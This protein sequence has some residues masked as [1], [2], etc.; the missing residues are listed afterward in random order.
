[1]HR[2]MKP[3]ISL[4]TAVL[5]PALIS[6]ILPAPGATTVFWDDL[7]DDADGQDV[8]TAQIGTWGDFAGDRNGIVRHINT[9]GISAPPGGG[10]K[11]LQ[12]RREGV[13]NTWARTPTL[14]GSGAS[15]HIEFDMYIVWNNNSHTA[16]FFVDNVL[17]THTGGADEL[18]LRVPQTFP[19]FAAEQSLQA[20]IIHHG[21]AS[22]ADTVTFRYLH[23][24]GSGDIGTPHAVQLVPGQTALVEQPW[25]PDATGPHTLTTELQYQEPGGGTADASPTQVQ[26]QSGS[27]IMTIQVPPRAVDGTYVTAIADRGAVP[28]TEYREDT[29]VL[30]IF[31]LAC[32]HRSNSATIPVS[33]SA[34]PPR[35][36]SYE[37]S[38]IASRNRRK[39]RIDERRR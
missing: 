12:V 33:L 9:Y 8:P 2:T 23:A 39:M 31:S 13:G 5:L 21:G 1:M 38:P 25:T 19:L 28:V 24:A 32:T 15:L 11:V 4:C 35:R 7:E 34:N 36:S 18:S 10:T 29:P 37:M 3:T 14:A 17:I 27:G 26:L 20:R 16:L 30:V 6:G 22:Q